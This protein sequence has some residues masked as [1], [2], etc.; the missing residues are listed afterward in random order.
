V[1]TDLDNIALVSVNAVST[2]ALHHLQQLT[3]GFVVWRTQD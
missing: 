3:I 1:E 2:D